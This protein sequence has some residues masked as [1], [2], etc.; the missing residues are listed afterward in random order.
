MYS[1][2]WEWWVRG[3]GSQLTAT[4]K[5]LQPVVPSYREFTVDT[6]IPTNFFFEL[7]HS[8]RFEKRENEEAIDTLENDCVFYF[9]YFS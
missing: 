8:A 6:F 2:V 3:V 5:R 7:S 1:S 4:Q 9:N